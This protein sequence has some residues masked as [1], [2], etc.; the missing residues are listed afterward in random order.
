MMRQAD[1]K[2]IRPRQEVTRFCPHCG[3]MTIQYL[4]EDRKRYYCTTCGAYLEGDEPGRW[5]PK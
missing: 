5:T 3:T 1:D 2:D 4:S